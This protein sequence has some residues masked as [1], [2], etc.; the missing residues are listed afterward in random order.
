MQAINN[1]FHLTIRISATIHFSTFDQHNKPHQ[2]YKYLGV[3]FFFT[4]QNKHMFLLLKNLI[5]SFYTNLLPLSLSHTE[6]IKLSNIQLIPILAYRLIDNSLPNNLL[7][8]LD[9]AIWVNIASQG[10]LSLGTPN[11]FV[12]QEKKHFFH[13]CVG[14]PRK[15][16]GRVSPPPPSDPPPYYTPRPCANPPPPIIHP[17]YLL[18]MSVL[19]IIST[20]RCCR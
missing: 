4:Q 1:A 2:Y 20:F 19:H 16:G 6:L 15:R 3:F 11:S 12:W 17:C 18:Y 7:D 5:T 14:H 9:H 8:S 10:N 13:F